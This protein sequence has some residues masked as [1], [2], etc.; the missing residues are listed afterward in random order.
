MI[1]TQK[2]GVLALQLK[3]IPIHYDLSPPNIYQK[4][5]FLAWGYLIRKSICDELDIE[6][7]E[8][9]IGYRISPDTKSHEIYL[10]ETA[11]NGAGY[12][13]FLNGQQD[14]EISKKVF[15]DNLN[16]NGRIY[17]TLLK[18]SHSNDCFSSCYDC[19]RDYYNQ[20]HHSMLNWRFALDLAELSNNKAAE[21]NFSQEYWTS[22]FNDYL[23]KLISNKYGGELENKNNVYSIKF[24]TG[25]STLIKHPFWS[26]EY[27]GNL[28]GD[29]YNETLHLMDL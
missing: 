24:K 14:I 20:K 10:V 1:A 29:Q 2:T 22:F 18:E 4:A 17:S 13:N 16:K 27:I 23:V 9:N 21:M 28:V 7:S 8:F 6:N 26:E 15:I 25:K 12:T 3:E 11:D 19:L 5:I